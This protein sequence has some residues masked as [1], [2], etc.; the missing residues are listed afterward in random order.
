MSSDELESE[1]ASQIA[2]LPSELE[3]NPRSLL[4]IFDHPEPGIALGDSETKQASGGLWN[5]F[6]PDAFTE[7]RDRIDGEDSGDG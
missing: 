3:S 7:R 6:R 1:S 5:P 4:G 2:E